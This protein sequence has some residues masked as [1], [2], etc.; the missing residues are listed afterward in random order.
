MK[1]FNYDIGKYGEDIA[2][3][4]L[5]RKNYKIIH[6]NFSNK[7][8]E[9]DIISLYEDMIVFT[10]VK[11]RYNYNFGY[12]IESVTYNKRRTI[13]NV[14]KY[15]IHINNLYKYNIRFDICEVFLNKTDEKYEINY[16]ENAFW[17]YTLKKE[18]MFY[19][20]FYN[21]LVKKLNLCISQGPFSLSPSICFVVPYPAFSSK[22]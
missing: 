4:Y 14:A 19:H 21:I 12:P 5:N 3:E 9:I 16:I 18:D 15:Y 20:I 10:E 6:R 1:K 22:A 17:K 13:I 8:G 7:Q 2:C 11:S